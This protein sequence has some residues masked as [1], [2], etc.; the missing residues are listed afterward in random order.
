MTT[1][2]DDVSGIFWDFYLS[3]SYMKTVGH[4]FIDRIKFS[5]INYF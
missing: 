4:K 3:L 2:K 5:P 1:K